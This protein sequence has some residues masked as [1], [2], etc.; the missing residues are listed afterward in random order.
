MKG[1]CR[2][3]KQEKDSDEAIRIVR[4]AP[5]MVLFVGKDGGFHEIHPDDG[6]KTR[7]F[8]PV[9]WKK[10]ENNNGSNDA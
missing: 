5:R 2:I 10:K 9:V 1:R 4:I 8:R 3:C 6:R 7:R